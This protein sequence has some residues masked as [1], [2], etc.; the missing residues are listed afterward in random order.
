MPSQGNFAFNDLHGVTPY[1]DTPY[2][3]AIPA[4]ADKNLA[5]AFHFYTLLD[6]NDLL[7]V[8]ALAAWMLVAFI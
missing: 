1:S 3:F 8:V 7:G 5:T 6:V 4:H 2:F